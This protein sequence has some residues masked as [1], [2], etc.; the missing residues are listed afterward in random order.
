MNQCN[1]TAIV[2]SKPN[3]P[4][5]VQAKTILQANNVC[6]EEQE[7]GTD[8]SLPELFEKIGHPVR[9]APQIFLNG[10]HVSNVMQLHQAIKDL[11]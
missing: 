1:H 9:S 11:S 7:I 8:I 2:Y 5:C 6:F 10:E 3:C 4:Q